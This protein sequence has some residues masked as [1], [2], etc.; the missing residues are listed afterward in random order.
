MLDIGSIGLVISIVVVIVA[1]FAIIKRYRIAG[2]DELLVITGNIRGT[3]NAKVIHGGGAFVLPLIQQYKYLSLTPFNIDIP[4]RGALSSQNIRVN[5]PSNFTVAIGSTPD[6]ISAAA[7]KL[8]SLDKRGIEKLS[9]EIIT[10]QLRATIA[11]MTIEEINVDR[12]KFLTSV[13]KN[14]GDELAKIGIEVINVNIKDITDDSN[15]LSSLGEKAAADVVNRAQIDVAEANK[16][17]AIGTAK[18]NTESEIAVA[19]AN[20]DSDIGV[21]T[22]K[23]TT[24]I[25]TARLNALT[26]AGENTSAI[27]IAKTTA[28]REVAESEALKLSATAKEV[29][30]QETLKAG[31]DAKTITDNALAISEKAA[32]NASIIV[33]AE[34]SKDKLILESEAKKEE[35]KLQGEGEGAKLR[36]IEEG[37]AEGE[38]AN[39]SKQAEGIKELV[40]AAG[41]AEAAGKLLMIQQMPQI[42]EITASA[43]A[44]IKIDKI[45]VWDSGKGADGK[46]ATSGLIGD[47]TSM[48]PG[49]L[50]VMEKTGYNIPG[51]MGTEKPTPT[52]VEV[53]PTETK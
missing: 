42:A 18:A 19:E 28:D 3:K 45:T 44:N 2:S 29:K 26:V 4:L 14:V 51:W 38:Y 8:L 35:E 40:E 32:L 31:Y 25:E 23:N 7:E 20:K 52:T 9:D 50:D 36:A 5:V 39:L 37:K 47:L 16:N 17:G 10:G 21:A 13:R 53:E 24:D 43:I 34:I 30:L 11:D 12:D 46:G 15:Y 1:V 6:L 41:S 22:A 48:M 49:M 33:P 27:S